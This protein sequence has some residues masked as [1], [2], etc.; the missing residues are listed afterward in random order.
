MKKITKVALVFAIIFAIVGTIC[1][2]ASF[3]MGLTWDRLT[4][5]VTEGKFNFAFEHGDVHEDEKGV[6]KIP[7]EK[8]GDVMIPD[9]SFRNLDIEFAAGTLEIVYAD[10]EKVEVRRKNVTNFSCYVEEGTLHIEGGIK[11]G[12]NSNNGSIV[13]SIPRN[14]TFDE[15]DLEL[16]AGKASITGLVAN[17]VDIEVGAGEVNLKGLDTKTLDTGVGAGKL[18]IELIGEE[19]DYN[20]DAECG[21][22]EIKIGTASIS[23][24]GGSK[25]TNHPG[26]SRFMDLECGMGEIQIEFQNQ[27]L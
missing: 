27:N 5:M 23:G 24:M 3:A 6:V 20:Y 13:V 26:A 4:G 7:D 21:M 18:Y 17:S 2:I 10:V 19:S 15:V 9:E 1:I 8:K 11:I 22:G 25:E 14:T 12:V 16:D